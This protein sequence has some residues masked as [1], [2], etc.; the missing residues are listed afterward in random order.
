VASSLRPCSHQPCPAALTPLGAWAQGYLLSLGLTLLLE[1][2]I[3]AAGLAALCG[4]RP[5]FGVAAGIAVNLISHPL[6]IL[7]AVPALQPHIG[8]WPAVALIEILVWPLEAILLYAWLRRD[9]GPLL[10]LSFVAN[11]VSLSVGLLVS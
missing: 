2:P 1:V 3:Y 6:G 10:A 4:V 9:L 11:G 8:Y 5:L 7:I